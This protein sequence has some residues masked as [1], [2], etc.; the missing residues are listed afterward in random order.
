MCRQPVERLQCI[1]D[2]H[3]EAR[4]ET[5]HVHR[6]QAPP[7]AATPPRPGG[8]VRFG[9]EVP[10]GQLGADPLKGLIRGDMGQVAD[11][12]EFHESSVPHA[13]VL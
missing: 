10:P 5:A 9:G 7:P 3:L 4:A 1:C 12:H 6:K 2:L 13:C 11:E 8:V